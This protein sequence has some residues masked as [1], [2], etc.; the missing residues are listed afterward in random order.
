LFTDFSHQC[1]EDILRLEK[2]DDAGPGMASSA[3]FV[4]KKTQP[5]P[6]GL[7]KRFSI[8]SFSTKPKHPQTQKF[9]TKQP[10]KINQATRRPVLESTEEDTKIYVRQKIDKLRKEIEEKERL[11]KWA[12]KELEVLERMKWVKN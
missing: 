1:H 2:C 4:T 6:Q 11:L 12:Q 10:L 7:K 5:Q 9:V 3:S 8:A